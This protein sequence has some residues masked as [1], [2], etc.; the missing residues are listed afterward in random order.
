[1]TDENWYTQVAF[2]ESTME[3]MLKEKGSVSLPIRDQSPSS[4]EEK[5]LFSSTQLML[6]PVHAS[7]CNLACFFHCSS[8]LGVAT[9]RRRVRGEGWG[10]RV[11]LSL[12]HTYWALL[13]NDRLAGMC[14]MKSKVF[15]ARSSCFCF[16]FPP[17]FLVL[18][19]PS[20]LVS[21]R[22]SLSL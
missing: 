13:P 11:F 2:S 5:W 8:E 15:H 3:T 7:S 12:L 16:L 19:L 14:D 1:M 10:L 17:F 20:H 22:L 21:S 18:S 9:G 4:H 6:S